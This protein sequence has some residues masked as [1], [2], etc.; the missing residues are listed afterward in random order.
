LRLGLA[1]LID[2]YV[3]RL[4]CLPRRLGRGLVGHAP[5]ELRWHR[6]TQ[7]LRGIAIIGEVDCAD[8]DGVLEVQPLQHD[9][10]QCRPVGVVCPRQHGPPSVANLL[11]RAVKYQPTVVPAAASCAAAVWRPRSPA[12]WRSRVIA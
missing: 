2:T 3:P 9:A 11:D 6:L 10:H 12:P 4:Q 5:R 8:V 1:H 7:R